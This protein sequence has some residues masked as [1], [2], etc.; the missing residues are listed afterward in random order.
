[1]NVRGPKSFNDLRTVNG[2]LRASFREVCLELK[3]PEN[4]AHWDST[5]ADAASTA[6][7]RQIR[8]LFAI[9][10]PDMLPIQSERSLGK[11]PR[12]YE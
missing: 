3:L 8:A 9:L 4:D 5:M 2:N 12:L 1:M 7:P 11:V 10:L 6:H